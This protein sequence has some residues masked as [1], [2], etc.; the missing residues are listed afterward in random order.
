M[1][2]IFCKYNGEVRGNTI[3]IREEV[4]KQIFTDIKKELG[5]EFHSVDKISGEKEKLTFPDPVTPKLKN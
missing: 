1:M 5:M 3:I 2:N 4:H